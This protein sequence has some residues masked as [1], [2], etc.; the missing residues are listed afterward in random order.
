MSDFVFQAVSNKRIAILTTGTERRQFIH[1]NDVCSALHTA[2]DAHLQGV[3]DITSFEW[4]SILEMAR[5]IADE[6]GAEIIRGNVVGSTPITP[7]R[8]RV[9]GWLPRVDL[10]EGIRRMIHEIQSKLS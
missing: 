8:E 10:C 3:Y 7:I 2:L 9:P 6:T 1:I 4:V 5:V